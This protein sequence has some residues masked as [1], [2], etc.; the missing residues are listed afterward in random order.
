MSTLKI[1]E[2][3]H[4]RRATPP[5]LFSK[6]AIDKSV[7]EQLL[8]NA[9]WAPNHKKTEPWRF[10]VYTGEAKE[11]LAK[12]CGEIL[13][14]AQAGGFDV[15]TEKIEK[16][17]STVQKVPVAIA[18]IL[19]RDPAQRLPEWEEIAAVSMAVQNMWLTA[20]EMDLAAFWATPDFMAL[21]NDVLEIKEGQKVLGFFYVG[22]VMIDYPSPGRGDLDQKITWK[23]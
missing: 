19:Q 5:R 23:S 8:E 11:Q 6:T 9:H 10:Q 20:T 13:T 17:V 16:F 21:F 1:T 14:R 3:I 4:K 22:E 15:T 7:I 12:G 18:I 2:T